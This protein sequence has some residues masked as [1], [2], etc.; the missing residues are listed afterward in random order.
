MLLEIIETFNSMMVPASG[1]KP[2]F[3]PVLSALL[4]PIIQVWHVLI[5]VDRLHHYRNFVLVAWC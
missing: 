1:K 5:F 4:D 3:D 2:A